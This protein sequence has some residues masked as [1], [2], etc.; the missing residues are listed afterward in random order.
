[1][2]DLT[3]SFIT[4]N[5]GLDLQS[6]KI[7]APPGT[8]LDMLNYEQVDFQGQKRIDG[9]ARY[10]G[11]KGSYIDDFLRVEIVNPSE[12]LGIGSIVRTL[13]G[14]RV[15]G[16]LV[17][18]Y[19]GYK[20]LAIIDETEVRLLSEPH[21]WGREMGLEPEEHYQLILQYNEVL[22]NRTTELPG[23]VAGLH[24]FRDRLYAV[25]SVP[26]V[27]VP[28]DVFPNEM[29][30]G[31]TVLANRDGVVY[32][33]T[34]DIVGTGDSDI[35][36]F[37]VSRGEAQ[38]LEDFG[39]PDQYG[40]QFNHL[41]WRVPFENGVSLYGDLAALNQNRQN[42]GVQGPTSVEGTKGHP[43]ILTQNLTI[44]NKTP[45][46]NGWKNWDTPT[47]YT[48]SSSNVEELDSRY[49]YADGYVSWDKESNT[50]RIDSNT[51]QEYAAS[52]TVEV[53]LE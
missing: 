26:A 46:V 28:S 16:I 53:V 20:D 44:D 52:A 19:D 17:G 42:V 47:N 45:Q 48:L 3:P 6:P 27:H 34:S 15:F 14:E 10:D 36:S 35:A 12:S 51:L 29:Y 24:W 49:V 25:A 22:R 38:A 9:Y 5:T 37:F 41:G 40:W 13:D 2:S 43:L 1:M 50:I 39:S 11:S 33:G 7:A 18:E 32:L 8:A 21:I 4:L 30:Q 23:P 31:Y